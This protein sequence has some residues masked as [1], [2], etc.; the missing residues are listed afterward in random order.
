MPAKMDENYLH[1]RC[2]SL[3]LPPSDLAM[4]CMGSLTDI[5]GHAV[6]LFGPYTFHVGQRLIL[7][8]DRPL[9]L[10]GRALD[11]LQL[12]VERAGEVVS[13][14]ELIARVWPGTVVEAINLRVHIAALRRALGEARAELRYIAHV[15]RQGYCFIASVQGR[16]ALSEPVLKPLHNLPARLTPIV[17]RDSYVASVVRH[18]LGKRLV[19]LVGPGGVGK[20][21]VTL[22]SAELL[23]QHYKDGVWQLDVGAVDDPVQAVEQMAL[24]VEHAQCH[25]LLVLDNAEHRLQR[26]CELVEWVLEVAPHVSILVSSREPLQVVGETVLAV[27]ALSVPPSTDS[28]SVDEAFGYSAVQLFVLRARA[29]QQDWVL[30]EQDIDAVVELCRRLDG[31]PLAIELTACH[32]DALGLVGLLSQSDDGLQGLAQGRRTAVAR[33]QSLRATLDCSYHHLSPLEQTVLQRV[34]V[35]R[36]AFTLAALIR[37]AACPS[38]PPGLFAAAV[39]GLVLKSFLTMDQGFGAPRYCLLNTG[40]AYARAKLEE[41]GARG[42]DPAWPTLQ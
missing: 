10:G 16:A 31:L 42:P 37:V 27:P 41:S 4:T 2:E 40:R 26:C 12:L 32:I 24:T 8:G 33:H 19:T 14:D 21:T 34:S 18:L 11:I 5:N 3:E 17:G 30:R 36:R 13:K 20:S 6:L 35:F 7:D 22:R 39:E 23:I 38:V 28:L 9:S 15:P 25:A 29:R 1:W